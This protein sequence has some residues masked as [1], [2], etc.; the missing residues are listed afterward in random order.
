[1]IYES[2]KEI[3]TL[4]NDSFIPLTVSLKFLNTSLIIHS[5]TKDN[6]RLS[7]TEE[8]ARLY[9]CWLLRTARSAQGYAPEPYARFRTRAKCGLRGRRSTWHEEREIDKAHVL[10]AAESPWLEVSTVGLSCRLLI[11]GTMQQMALIAIPTRS[12][13]SRILLCLSRVRLSLPL[14]NFSLS[15]SSARSLCRVLLSSPR[16]FSHILPRGLLPPRRFDPTSRDS[17]C[18]I[19]S[20]GQAC[21]LRAED[22]EISSRVTI[23]AW[24]VAHLK[25]TAVVS[26]PGVFSL[27]TRTNARVKKMY[28]RFASLNFTRERIHGIP[29]R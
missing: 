23:S 15:P 7:A 10:R 12:S 21:H 24:S 17:I 25:F 19:S 6:I 18:S 1:M 4:A 16:R 3:S 13:H 29:C 14:P 9:I 8:C 27:L 26:L 22:G 20:R 2:A 5:Q 28:T 11:A